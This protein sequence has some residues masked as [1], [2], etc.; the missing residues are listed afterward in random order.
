ML[1]YCAIR[2]AAAQQRRRQLQA[3]TSMLSPVTRTAKI[4]RGVG[5]API[6]PTK[7]RVGI[8]GHHS[9]H[10]APVLRSK[11]VACAGHTMHSGSVVSLALNSAVLP[12][13]DR[14][15]CGHLLLTANT[16][17]GQ[18]VASANGLW[19][20]ARAQHARSATASSALRPQGSEQRDRKR[21]KSALLKPTHP[22]KTGEG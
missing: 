11:A 16:S 17:S 12:C 14:P 2:I 6:F 18:H 10:T 15:R 3:S 9:P 19:Q 5:G 20:A 4:D 8:V 13:S 1:M 21:L 22:R 7:G